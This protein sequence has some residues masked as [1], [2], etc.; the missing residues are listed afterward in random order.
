MT[1]WRLSQVSVGLHAVKR[2]VD[3]FQRIGMGEPR[4]VCWGYS[5][6]LSRSMFLEAG[7]GAQEVRENNF[8]NSLNSSVRACLRINS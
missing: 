8:S 4:C 2:A 5:D 1:D 6:E 7:S 3:G